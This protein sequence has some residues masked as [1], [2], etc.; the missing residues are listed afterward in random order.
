MEKKIEV[1]HETL[2]KNKLQMVIYFILFAILIVAFIY[3]GMYDFNPELPDNERF[4]AEFNLVSEDNVFEYI[5]ASRA[6]MVAS[7]AKGIVLFGSSYSNWVNYYA[8]IVND[9]AKEVGVDKIYYY[10]FIKNREDNN[11]TY[12]AIVERLSNYV[13]YNDYGVADIYA[14]SLLVVS[15]D[16]VLLFDTETSFRSSNIVPSEY[17]NTL[18]IENKKSELRE[19][20]KVYLE[21]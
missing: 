2:F 19:I 10:N 20:F 21:S 4:A 3:I 16:E 7:G 14:P 11:G 8:S 13:T 18:N 12:E 5:N 17:W 15:G 9:V 6:L 1:K